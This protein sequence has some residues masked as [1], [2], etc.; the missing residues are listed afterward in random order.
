MGGAFP[1]D[2]SKSLQESSKTPCLPQST[3]LSSSQK[4]FVSQLLWCFAIFVNLMSIGKV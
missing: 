4:T 3:E 2:N 1:W